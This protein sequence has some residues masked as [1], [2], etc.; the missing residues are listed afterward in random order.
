VSRKL[1]IRRAT[2]RDVDLLVRHRRRMW[3]EIGGFTLAQI[4]AADPVYRRW[5]R[6]RL[7]SGT[8]VG[9]V[10]VADGVPA[11][12]GCVWIQPVQPNPRWAEGLQPYL[13]SMFTEA[14]FRGRG[15]AKRLVETATEWCRRQG[16]PRFALHASDAGRPIYEAL[17]WQRTWEMRIEIAPRAA[18]KTARRRTS[19]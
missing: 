14:D 17:G 6:A 10:V 5:A 13:L 1:S 9:W 19:G 8:L 2:V 4:V 7:R 12:S 11:A 16:Y 18:R 3:E 15:F